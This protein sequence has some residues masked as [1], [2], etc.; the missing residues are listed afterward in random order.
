MGESVKK[1]VNLRI[2]RDLIE[3]AK[4]MRINLSQVLESSLGEILRR[5]R[6]EIWMAGNRDAIDAYNQRVEKRGVFSRGLR[7][8]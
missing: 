4:A 5:R 3:Q 6:Q 1:A 7:R 8:F 2:D